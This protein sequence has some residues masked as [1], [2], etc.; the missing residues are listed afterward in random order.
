MLA[1]IPAAGLSVFISKQQPFFH[2]IQCRP[3]ASGSFTSL[4]FAGSVHERNLPR[5]REPKEPKKRKK[6]TTAHQE[7][8]W[9]KG[10]ETEKNRDATNII[11]HYLTISISADVQSLA[12]T[13]EMIRNHC[14]SPV[15]EGIENNTL[16]SSSEE[17]IENRETR[18]E[19][20]EP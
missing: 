16:H 6:R 7:R 11:I 12:P 14:S 19:S 17:E 10:A 2:T 13:N 5:W 1:T 8:S 20:K 9:H 4:D 15:E 18:T 3:S